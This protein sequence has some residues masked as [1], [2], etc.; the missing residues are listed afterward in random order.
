[1][2]RLLPSLA[3]VV[4][5]LAA[6]GCGN[7]QPTTLHGDTEGSYL[8]LGGLKYQ[9]QISR[10]LNPG[11]IEDRAYLVGLNGAQRRLPA[12]QQWFGVFVRVENDGDRKNVRAA[13]DF[14]IVDTQNNKFRPIALAP[15]N[16][17]AY[18]GGT[19]QP[20][21]VVPAP[22]SPPGQGSIQGSLL[23]F[24]IPVANFENRPLELQI[25]SAA[26]PGKTA[27]VDLDV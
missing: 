13:T 24:K 8:D 26:A 1:M 22:D 10:L 6:A 7:K 9:I 23:L 27:T 16:V 17:F 25:R 2:R 5:A 20:K 4:L 12:G 11:S 14:T 3:V 15:V 21:D 18:R 19:L